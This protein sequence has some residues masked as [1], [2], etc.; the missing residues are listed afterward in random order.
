M[1]Q[2]YV[3]SLLLMSLCYLI[4]FSSCSEELKDEMYSDIKMI[5]PS[6]TAEFKVKTIAF[7]EQTLLIIDDV[8][9]NLRIT[10][11]HLTVE[12]VR[13]YL[14]D[15][16][17]GVC[18][19]EP[20][21]FECTIPVVLQ[22]SGHVVKMEYD[23][24]GKG[25]LPGTG[26]TV[27]DIKTSTPSNYFFLNTLNFDD[28]TFIEVDTLN[29]SYLFNMFGINI[30]KVSFYADNKLI[31]QDSV[32]PFCYRGFMDRLSDDSHEF[33]IKYEAETNKGIHL[34]GCMKTTFKP[35][36]LYDFIGIDGLSLDDKSYIEIDTLDIPYSIKK[37]ALNV[38]DV[39]YFIDNK[40]IAESIEPP[41]SFRGFMP[42]LE[43]G[44]HVFTYQYQ[45][46]N[47]N[48]QSASVSGCDTFKISKP[49]TYLSVEGL[50]LDNKSYIEIDT[51]DIPYSI[52]KY[53]LNV[54]DVKYFIDNKLIA[55]SIEP[56]LSFRGFMPK[57]EDG[58][59]V[60][61]YQ[62][63]VKNENG[64]SASVSGC[65]TFKI[66]KPYAHL[67]VT[68]LNFQDK[69]YFEAEG[70]LSSYSLKR[71]GLEV[72]NSCIYVDGHLIG[73]FEKPPYA[74]TGLIKK[75]DDINHEISMV[76]DIITAD[77]ETD[78]FSIFEDEIAINSTIYFS[79]DDDTSEG[80]TFLKTSDISFSWDIY[81]AQLKV[82]EIR[83]Y[84]NDMLIETL[85]AEPYSLDYICKNYPIGRYKLKIECTVEDIH[86]NQAVIGENKTFWVNK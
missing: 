5:I 1:K 77:G 55:E 65:D 7:N 79:L 72:Q 31:K 6:E 46:K 66:S 27:K 60:F 37:Y 62:Y 78:T 63:Q 61:T 85:H 68:G 36:K 25:F 29:F 74:Y 2:K 73:D 42:K 10:P 47:E 75:W 30:K 67:S 35:D 44:N 59:H 69:T 22:D 23:L 64:Q 56:P 71:K 20:Y 58:N 52:K 24:S 38:V 17:L 48:G 12:E 83:Y 33:N 28:K 9:F 82:K 45:V 18:Q 11:L 32:K 54:V 80:N 3:L 4:A 26:L 16:L 86:G 43:D 76:C 53:A 8:S 70:N 41:L 40:L 34:T 51:L 84:I 81:K 19:E 39:K 57:L 50:S 49:Y 15:D 21:E 14:D 13:F